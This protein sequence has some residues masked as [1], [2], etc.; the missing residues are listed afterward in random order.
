[1][2]KKLLPLVAAGLFTAGSAVADVDIENNCNVNLSGSINYEYGDLNIT[3]EQGDNILINK[4]HELFIDGKKQH[5]EASEQS[6]VNSYYDNISTAVPMTVSI[7]IDAVQIAN[8]AISSAFSELLGND[9]E[10]ILELDTFFVGVDEQIKQ[11]FYSSD[12]SYRFNVNGD[13]TEDWVD[14]AW[15]A[16]FEDKIEELISRSIG[17]LLI[18]IGTAMLLEDDDNGS[19]DQRMETFGDAMEQRIES[20]TAAIEQK[21]DALCL[22]LADADYTEGKMQQNITGLEH[23]NLLEINDYT[24]KM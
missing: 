21:A 18:S 17:K 1:M 22:V 8:G 12:G 10:L 11:K 5:L 13:E 15:E 19:F 3:T 20:Q 23:L 4:D 14:T 16:E 7:A 2:M 9:D 24:R 6:W